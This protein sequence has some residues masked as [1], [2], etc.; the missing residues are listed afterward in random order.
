MFDP[1]DVRGGDRYTVPPRSGVNGESSDGAVLCT[2]THSSNRNGLRS[3]KCAHRRVGSNSTT[4][5]TPFGGRSRDEVNVNDATHPSR[6]GTTNCAVRARVP[7]I[8]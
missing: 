6:A 4:L 5:A 2:L 8:G 7:A 1:S 3:R